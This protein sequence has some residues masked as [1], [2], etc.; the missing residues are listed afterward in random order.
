[1]MQRKNLVSAWPLCAS[2]CLAILALP[3]FIN[4]DFMLNRVARYLTLRHGVDGAQPVLGLC[5]HPQPRPG[6]ELRHRFL[7]HGNGAQ[8]PHRSRCIP[9]SEGLPDFMV[10][11][12]VE[13]AALVLAAILLDD[14]RHSGGDHHSGVSWRRR[15]AGSC[16]AAGSTGVY[17]AIITLATLVVVNLLII[18]QQRFTGGFNGITDLGPAGALRHHLR[19][20]QCVDLLPRGDLPHRHA[21]SLPGPSPRARPASSFRRSATRKRAC[22]SSA[23]TS[24]CSRR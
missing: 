24:P 4:D 22:A 12:N 14:V 23:M 16:S 18:D 9:G 21:C 7:L 13:V 1:M 10:W 11:N 2:L 17:V 3:A 20:L 19:C 5:G 6:D 15:S 8:A